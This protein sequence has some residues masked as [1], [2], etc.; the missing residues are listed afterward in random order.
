MLAEVGYVTSSA[1][2]ALP[3]VNWATTG[4]Q[5][6]FFTGENV[7]RITISLAGRRDSNRCHC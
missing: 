1:G 3:L 2:T 4:N 5:T 7:T 6:V